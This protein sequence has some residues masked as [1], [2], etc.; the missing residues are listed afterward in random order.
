MSDAIA[1]RMRI[2]T[3]AREDREQLALQDGDENTMWQSA[4]SMVASINSRFTAA[5]SVS[6]PDPTLL[7]IDIHDLW[8]TYWHGAVNTAPDSPKLDRLALQIIQS[9][10]Q[11]TL[12]VTTNSGNLGIAAAVAMTSEGYRIWTDLPFMVQDMTA[13][14]IHNSAVMGSAQRLSGAQFLA[15]L[16]AAGTASD[17]A[18]CGIALVVLREALETARGL[19]H[20]AARSRDPDRQL[21]DLSVA[22]LLPSANA[23]LFSAGR[24][25]VQLSDVEWNRCP[26]DVGKLGELVLAQS[27]TADPTFA[28]VAL[29]PHGGFSPRRW[30]W[31]LRRL[32][33]LATLASQDPLAGEVLDLGND[34]KHGT[35]CG[36]DERHGRKSSAT[37]G[38]RR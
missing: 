25:L 22:D 8:H 23:W 19:G 20:L 31:W 6:A 9:R 26:R 10:E 15:L 17:D 29:P 36:A 11:G 18:L 1:N 27:A 28:D 2:S 24:K 3:I 37:I 13:H 32:E 34:G 30:T 14:W 16:A 7:D 4:W 38:P 21:Q 12:A 5:D 35:H 33:Q